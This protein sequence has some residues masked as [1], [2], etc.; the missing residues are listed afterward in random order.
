MG[1]ILFTT[2]KNTRDRKHTRNMILYASWSVHF[3]KKIFDILVI[4]ED[5]IYTLIFFVFHTTLC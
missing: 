3:V 5:H 2:L 1:A 4:F